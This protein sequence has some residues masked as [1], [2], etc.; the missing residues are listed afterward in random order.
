MKNQRSIVRRTC[1]GAET[2]VFSP[3]LVR[4]AA[5]AALSFA[6]SCAAF[7]QEAGAPPQ[8]D[9]APQGSGTPGAA[10]ELVS[11]G[12]VLSDLA[13]EDSSIRIAESTSRAAYETYRD[14]VAQSYPQI[15]FAT[16][17]QGSPLYGYSYTENA[18]APGL[19]SDEG[20]RTHTVAPGLQLSQLL[21]TAGT[22][23]LAL[24]N[25]TTVTSATTA[26]PGGAAGDAIRTVDQAPSLSLQISQPVLVNGK[27]IDFS[28]FGAG[29][30]TAE[31]GWEQGTIDRRAAVNQAVAAAAG[32]YLQAVNL[33]RQSAR[34]ERAVALSEQRLD[35]MQ[36]SLDQGRIAPSELRELELELGTRRETLLQVRFNLRE[37]VRNLA[38]VSGRTGLMP[39]NL[40]DEFTVPE[41]PAELAATDPGRFSRNTEIASR[42]LDLERTRLQ[43]AIDGRKFQSDL[44]LAL[45][46]RPRYPD[47]RTIASGLG[48]DPTYDLDSFSDSFGDLFTEDASLEYSIGVGL[49]IPLYT[50]G[51]RARQQAIQRERETAASE[52]LSL[53]RRS[54]ADRFEV[55][56]LEREYHEER[57]ALFEEL[58]EHRRE[59]LAREERLLE[60]RATT[61]L[62]VETVRLDM[63]DAEDSLWFSRAE[64]YLNT[65]DILALAGEDLSGYPGLAAERNNG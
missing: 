51:R 15:Y 59:L 56:L 41:L 3:R 21:P 23:S 42:Q 37:L 43:G 65:L 40:S 18:N 34:L 58:V 11:L 28:L 33:R 60:L 39:E 32:L 55:L 5:A 48:E 8:A 35:Q 50:G 22:L 57:V 47:D 1:P 30:R 6:L 25:R 7:T 2:R 26:A 24:S 13:A 45:S 12:M 44:T 53:A 27:L 29:I 20:V 36:V 54:V 4:A 14:T 62:S 16:D 38:R 49:R 46:L 10:G 61:P 31:I 19:K 63:V 9:A 17:A 52:G 64:L